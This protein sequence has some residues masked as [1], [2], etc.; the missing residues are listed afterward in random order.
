MSKEENKN[1]LDV[2]LKD[3]K[4][5]IA[6]VSGLVAVVILIAAIII[7]SGSSAVKLQSVKGD[8]SSKLVAL[9]NN[10]K[11]N[12]IKETGYLEY[13]FTNAQKVMFTEALEEYDNAALII[14]VEI[15]PSAKQREI[16]IPGV[17]FSFKTGFLN[18]SD[19]SANG[20]Y[21]SKNSPDNEKITVSSNNLSDLYYRLMNANGKATMD[22]SLGV[23]KISS[24]VESPEGFFVYSSLGL[25]VVSVCVAP[26]ELGYDFSLP[27]PFFGFSTNGGTIDETGVNVDFSGASFLFPVKNSTNYQMPQI[28]VGLSEENK[29]TVEKDYKA[30][31][32]ING[33][34]LYV[35]NIQKTNALLIPAAA[36]RNPYG[37]VMVSDSEKIITSV[38][39]KSTPKT[40]AKNTADEIITPIITDPGLIL[41]WNQNNW[42]CKDYEIFE[43]DRFPGILFFDMKNHAVQDNFFRRLAFYV[44][45]EGYRGKLMT[46]EQIGDMHGYNA[47]DY[48]PESLAKFFNEAEKT[49]FKLNK[50]EYLLKEIL[51]QNGLLKQDSEK[52]GLVVPGSGGLVS[53]SRES[54][55]WSR[56]RLLAHEGWHTLFFKYE[57]FR[58]FV[59]AVFYTMDANSIQFMKDYFNSQPSL[60][61]DLSDEYL[62]HNEFMAYIMQQP[63]NEVAKNFAGYANWYTVRVFAPDTA[64][65]VR[66]TEAR[67]FEDAATM[68]NDYVFDNYGVVCG[69]ISLVSHY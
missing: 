13:K 10:A 56:V 42:R 57:D 30:Q 6:S 38:I 4:I 60:G 64:R 47:H 15:E 65:F 29:S 20:K 21:L 32:N 58:N 49:N 62:L 54:P 50:E 35:K 25:K 23:G 52:E 34:K 48:S 61:Y 9:N 33:E 7:A 46:N 66:E 12:T 51:L 53:I 27:V 17:N 59:S 69:S 18:K 63:L 3:K 36:L 41:E 19:F 26:A 16:M 55:A 44:E 40:P 22:I 1:L 43:W 39:M 31:L 2:L 68:L 28:I 11:K 37:L 45:K 8:S 5:M 14:R 24:E 67:A